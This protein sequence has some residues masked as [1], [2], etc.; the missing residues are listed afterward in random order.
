MSGC[1]RGLASCF[2]KFQLSCLA[3]EERKEG[4]FREWF[5]MHPEGSSS[6]YDQHSDLNGGSEHYSFLALNIL[7]GESS[8][9]TE[10]KI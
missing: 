1:K 5:R 2:V 3:G 6:L 7:L 4:L 9:R 10:Y 8:F